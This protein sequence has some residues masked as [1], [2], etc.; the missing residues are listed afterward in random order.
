M[1]AGKGKSETLKSREREQPSGESRPPLY[2]VRV[3]I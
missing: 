3:P 1:A 2:G